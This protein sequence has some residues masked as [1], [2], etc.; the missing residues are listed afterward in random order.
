MRVGGAR[1]AVR[2]IGLISTLV[3]ARLL[4]PADFGLVA[5]A[6][7][8]Q[9]LVMAATEFGFN[10]ALIQFKDAETEDYCTAWTL[11]ILRGLGLALL[12]LVLAQPLA[13]F[14]GD[15]RLFWILATLALSPLLEGFENTWFINYEK[16]MRFSPLS[17]LMIGVKL[18]GVLTTVALAILTHSYWALIAGMVMMTLVRTV[19]THVMHPGPQRFMLRRWRRL[20]AFSGWL[21][22]AEFMGAMGSKLDN[23]ILQKMLSAHAVGIFSTSR[24]LTTMMFSEIAAPLRRVLF[25]ALSQLKAGSPEFRELYLL[26]VSCLFMILAPLGVGLALVADNAVPLLLGS[27]WHDAIGPVR[28]LALMLAAQTLSITAQSSVTAAGRT[29]LLFWRNLFFVP[30]RIGLFVLGVLWGGLTGGVLGYIAGG[31]LWALMN[32]AMAQAVIGDTLLA[33]F[34]HCGRSIFALAGMAMAVGAVRW[35]LPD[36]GWLGTDT[37]QLAL[38]TVVGALSYILFHL[39]LWQ[40]R[41][42][43]AGPEQRLLDLARRLTKRGF[44]PARQVT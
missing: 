26:S 22:G 24:E 23:I 3:T 33:S 2:G 7:G 44:R 39:A 37:L 5:I 18:S 42:R 41:G 40:I 6:A 1:M 20:M 27:Q 19:A 34:T 35:A 30:L 14:L 4:T 31:V 38:S 28:W 16:E 15:G 9:A 32:M 21:A 13:R 25:P 17:R 12:M 11:N 10:V 43:P 36:A 29:K 8:V